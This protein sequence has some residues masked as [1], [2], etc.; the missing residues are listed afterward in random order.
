MSTHGRKCPPMSAQK[1]F[2]DARKSASTSVPKKTFSLAQYQKARKLAPHA[3]VATNRV[4]DTNL[5]SHG[6]ENETPVTAA[7]PLSTSKADLR[8]NSPHRVCYE[9]RVAAQDAGGVDAACQPGSSQQDH[10]QCCVAPVLVNTAK[11]R[12]DEVALFARKLF[13]ALHSC[14]KPANWMTLK[15]K[16]ANKFGEAVLT[17]EK[18]AISTAVEAEMMRWEARREML[19]AV[20]RHIGCASARHV[21]Q[22]Y[23]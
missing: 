23:A 9:R 2:L 8:T 13:R 22:V 6:T 4:S 14:R 1:R 11:S 12:H 17:D 19:Q 16:I 10:Y 20:H 18:L 7:L 5:K 3:G 15:Q 21:R